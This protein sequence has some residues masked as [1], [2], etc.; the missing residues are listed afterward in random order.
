MTGAGSGRETDTLLVSKAVAELGTTSM[1]IRVAAW[2]FR[3]RH[4]ESPVKV[5]EGVFTYVAID[6]AGNKR[7]V[8]P[9]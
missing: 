3:Q 6:A 8:P 7:P 4:D 2:A 9:V 5:T 1:T